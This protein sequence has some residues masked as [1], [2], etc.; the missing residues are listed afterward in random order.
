MVFA[1]SLSTSSLTAAPGK[2]S[3]C[4]SCHTP[5]SAYYPNIY[6]QPEWYIKQELN[7]FK[8]KKRPSRIMFVFARGLS[9]K[10]ISEL[11]KYFSKQKCY[12]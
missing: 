4:K 6:G 5:N 12:K 7:N 10:D 9:D 11:A 3:V 1:L 2:A 8:S